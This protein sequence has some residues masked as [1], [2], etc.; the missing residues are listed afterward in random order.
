MAV[1]LHYAVKTCEQSSF[2][3]SEDDDIAEGGDHIGNFSCYVSRLKLLF[4]VAGVLF[5]FTAW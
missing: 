4:I 5:I 1:S 2:L 3:V